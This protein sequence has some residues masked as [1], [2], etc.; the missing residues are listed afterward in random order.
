MY[1]YHLGVTQHSNLTYV[2]DMSHEGRAFNFAETF[3]NDYGVVAKKNG[4]GDGFD[5]LPS[6]GG[7][8]EKYPAICVH[9][10]SIHM[11]LQIKYFR[12]IYNNFYLL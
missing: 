12:F 9:C 1:I 10:N 5:Y 11:F 6:Y 8:E 2:N 7:P 4:N 3:I